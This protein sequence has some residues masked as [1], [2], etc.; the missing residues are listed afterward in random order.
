M[1]NRL[2]YG[3]WV[4][5]LKHLALQHRLLPL[6]RWLRL[7]LRRAATYFFNSKKKEG[8]NAALK[9]RGVL[10]TAQIAFVTE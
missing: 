2:L 10:C 5:C 9:R 4:A 6:M 1:R 8:K 3:S 7:C